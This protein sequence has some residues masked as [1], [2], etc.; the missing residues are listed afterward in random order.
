MCQLC[1]RTPVNHV[2]GMNIKPGNDEEVVVRQGEAVSFKIPD[3]SARKR[4]SSCSRWK[5]VAKNKMFGCGP[6]GPNACAGRQFLDSRFRG[7]DE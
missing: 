5:P 2:P 7:N 4:E 3:S 6:N 1:L